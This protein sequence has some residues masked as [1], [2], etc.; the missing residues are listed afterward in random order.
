MWE[1]LPDW[2]LA[3][4]L[5]LAV[6]SG[7]AAA[8]VWLCLSHL[9]KPLYTSSCNGIQDLQGLTAGTALYGP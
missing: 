2:A 8:I 9:L 7:L 1:V 3:H 4:G 5:A 6:V